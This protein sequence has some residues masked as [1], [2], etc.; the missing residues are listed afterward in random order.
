MTKAESRADGGSK[1]TSLQTWEAAVSRLKR[2][3]SYQL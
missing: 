3:A 2:A 1:D